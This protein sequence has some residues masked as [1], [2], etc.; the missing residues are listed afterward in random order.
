MTGFYV[1]G[2]NFVFQNGGIEGISWLSEPLSS[3]R[4]NSLLLCVDLLICMKF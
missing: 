2:K 3:S 4:K 1:N